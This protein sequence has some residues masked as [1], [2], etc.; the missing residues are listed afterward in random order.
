MILLKNRYTYYKLL[1]YHYPGNTFL[2]VYSSG[3]NR[4]TFYY[5]FKNSIKLTLILFTILF[6]N[7][8]TKI[9][10]SIIHYKDVKRKR[11]ELP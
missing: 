10:M 9:T 3:T 7:I 5:L 4:I 11:L 8:H 6:Q 2:S 1:W